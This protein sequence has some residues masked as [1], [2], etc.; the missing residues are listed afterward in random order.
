MPSE[1]KLLTIPAT[2]AEY[3]PEDWPFA[4]K[5]S[6][7]SDFHLLQVHITPPQEHRGS[8][9]HHQQRDSWAEHGNE[10]WF[11]IPSY[12]RR[13]QEQYQQ[14]EAS[15]YRATTNRLS[16]QSTSS[17]TSPPRV[18]TISTSTD[19]N[20]PLP[21]SPSGSEKKRFKLRGLLRRESANHLRPEP[22]QPTCSTLSL[23]ATTRPCH[24]YSRSMPSSPREFNQSSVSPDPAYIPRASSAAGNHPEQFQNQPYFF[25]PQQ[26]QI[27][28]YPTT[29]QRAATMNNYFDSSI[30][31][32]A[33]TFPDSNMASASTRTTRES[34]LTKPRPHTWL[35][36]TEAFTDASQFHL[37]A[38]AT[39]GLPDADTD[40]LSPNAQPQLLGSLFARR[41]QNDTIPLPLQRNTV[42]R[43][44]SPPHR[45]WQSLEPPPFTPRSVSA[46]GTALPRLESTQRWE[47]PAHMAAVNLELEML[48]LDDERP[49]DDELPDYAQSQAE[50][51][52]KKRVEA[53][54]RARELE[55]RW[56]GSRR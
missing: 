19:L 39:T 23:D 35:S 32:R 24:N 52:E 38:E 5:L 33:Q 21:P 18:P 30:P 15:A 45:G 11:N 48:G 41:T 9:S 42:S 8:M 29:L 46:P 26:E 27:Q 10:L 53:S 16:V 47:P 2:P 12:A 14:S 1:A 36:P 43:A 20:K 4:A 56:R 37:F 7:A 50:M 34:V 6:S 55:E 40:S 44:Q 3:N 54:A 13:Q 25:P 17:T 51:N 22:F 28:T 49:P 31:P